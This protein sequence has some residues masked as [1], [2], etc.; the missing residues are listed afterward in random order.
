MPYCHQR[1][2]VLLKSPSSYKFSPEPWISAEEVRERK[3]LESCKD[4]DPQ[5]HSL[6]P[7]PVGLDLC[8]AIVIQSITLAIL[9]TYLPTSTPTPFAFLHPFMY[10]NPYTTCREQ[11]FIRLLV[12]K[13]TF[14]SS[15]SHNVIV[16]QVERRC[17]DITCSPKSCFNVNP[18]TKM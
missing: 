18:K 4:S 14:F 12:L 15:V 17:L 10:V 11:A 1:I 5:R 8:S 2:F 3:E 6:K 13:Y 16:F 9:P 7:K